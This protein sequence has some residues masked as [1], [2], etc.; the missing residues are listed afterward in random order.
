MHDEEFTD[1]WRNSMPGSVAVSFVLGL[2]DLRCLAVLD[3]L[4]VR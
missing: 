1:S 4:R 3:L 2:S